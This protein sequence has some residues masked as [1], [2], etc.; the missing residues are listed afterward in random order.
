VK[1][2]ELRVPVNNLEGKVAI[3]TG[4]GRGIGKAISVSLAKAG[5]RIVLAARTR[6]QIEVVQEEILS[7]GGDA[8]GVPTDLT[9]DEDIQRLVEESQAKWGA[10]DILINNAGWGKRAPVVGASLTDWD[11]T[12]R[13]NLRAPMVLAKALLPNMIAK[14]EGAVINIGSVS[15][16]TGEANGA[17]Y[18]ASKFGLIGFTQSLYEEVREHSIKVAVI[19]PGFV[20][21]PLIPPN[22]QLDRSKMIQADDIARTVL[23]VLTS[24]ATCCPVEI[25]V[26]PQ[27]T[28]YR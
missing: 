13:L 27:R 1:R 18:S 7:Q 9:A 23:F 11:Q 10:V 20:D 22:R 17:A 25:T 14:R 8:L 16:K 21:T 26:R 19:L 28:P 12:F 6:E 2:E 5:C 15:G 3:V 4:A 24:P